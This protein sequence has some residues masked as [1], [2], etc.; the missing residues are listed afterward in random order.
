VIIY[1]R[2]DVLI[3]IYAKKKI[4][5]KYRYLLVYTRLWKLS[6]EQLKKFIYYICKIQKKIYTKPIYLWMSFIYYFYL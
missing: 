5:Y 6:I 1:K 4:E 3:H 2:N